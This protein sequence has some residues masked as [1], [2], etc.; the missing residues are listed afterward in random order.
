MVNAENFL[1]ELVP[2]F[3]KQL[4]GNLT[5]IY[6]HG[7]LAMDCYSPDLSDIDILVVIEDRLSAAEKRKLISAVLGLEKVYPTCRL[8]M[9]I[10][11]KEVLFPFQHPTPFELHYSGLYKERYINNSLYICEGTADPDIAAHI[12]VTY[13]RGMTLYGTPL[14]RVFS[15]PSSEQYLSSVMEDLKNARMGITEQPVYFIL[16]LCRTLYYLS[17]N[18]I[19]SKQEGGVWALNVVSRHYAELI[20]KALNEY[21]GQP[22]SSPWHRSEL[23]SFADTMMQLI[24]EKK[25]ER[26]VVR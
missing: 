24:T 5:G 10:L 1:H 16:N 14:R 22:G 11:L 25:K 18:K 4:K 6:L 19:S 13:H 12:T 15:L 9:S 23:L 26:M 8:E 7:S 2:G 17:E 21:N 3:R 20:T